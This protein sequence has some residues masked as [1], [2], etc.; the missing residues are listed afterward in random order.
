MLTPLTPSHL[1]WSLFCLLLLQ[2]LMSN[3]R[4]FPTMRLPRLQGNFGGCTNFGR[5]GEETPENPGPTCGNTTHFI[6]DCPKR[7]KCDY[8]N[9]N[10]YNNKNDNR[11]DY[12]MKNRFRDKKKNNIN[13][14]LS[15][16][17]AS[18]SDFDFSSEDSS[19]SEGD[20][21]VNY[22]KKE[23][24]FTRF[25]LM[26]KGRSSRNDSDSDSNVSDDLTY[27]GLSSKVH[28]LEDSLCNEDKL[29]C[30][31]FR[32]NKDLNLKLENSF[33]E[34]AS[35]Q[36]MHNDM[37][38]KPCENCNMNMMNYADLWIMHT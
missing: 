20:E 14:I 24:D 37:S 12:K 7:K 4:I 5:R 19:S 29:L 21:N 18:L 11:N 36:S 38:V 30:R 35:L 33:A 22:K 34:I 3:M 28:K 25:C 27:D 2:L 16:A 31:V 13:K 26:D 1:L 15:R 9:K 6:P 17:C 32:E 10:D 8:S 23:D